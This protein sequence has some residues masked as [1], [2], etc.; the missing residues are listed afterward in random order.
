MPSR[1]RTAAPKPSQVSVIGVDDDDM[2]CESVRVVVLR[3]EGVLAVEPSE[4]AVADARHD[5]RGCR[6]RVAELDVVH[7]VRAPLVVERELVLDCGVG[8]G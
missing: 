3:A 4:E 5:R 7:L 1:S 8:V 6:Q 2:I